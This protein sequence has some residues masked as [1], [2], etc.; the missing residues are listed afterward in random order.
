LEVA[1]G[2]DGATDGGFTLKV[3]GSRKGGRAHIH[4]LPPVTDVVFRHLFSV[5]V[6]LQV[7]KI[8][9]VQYLA[10]LKLGVN[11]VHIVEHDVL[12]LQGLGR[13]EHTDAAVSYG[14]SRVVGAVGRRD[15]PTI[16]LGTEQAGG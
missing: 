4:R 11:V 9:P 8:H 13:G 16:R 1:Q 14:D 2:I 12:N 3:E 7:A 6:H 5:D 10:D 15:V